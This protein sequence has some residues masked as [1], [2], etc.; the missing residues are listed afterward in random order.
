M[1]GAARA[2]GGGVAAFLEQV[3]MSQAEGEEVVKVGGPAVGPVD[4]VVSVGARPV[5]SR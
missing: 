5:V 2:G 3:V 1:L 4:D